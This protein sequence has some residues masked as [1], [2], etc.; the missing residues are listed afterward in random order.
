MISG[1]RLEHGI[2]EIF[3]QYQFHNFITA[4]EYC[5]SV[6]KNNADPSEIE[7]IVKIYIQ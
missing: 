2:Q 7:K 3:Q 4:F 1:K 5:C 6:Y